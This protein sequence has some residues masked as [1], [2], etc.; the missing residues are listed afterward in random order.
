M[1]AKK[2]WTTSTTTSSCA[3]IG[4]AHINRKGEV[5]DFRPTTERPTQVW[6]GEKKISL[7]P[8]KGQEGLI[9][10]LILPIE[11]WEEVRE[12][13]PTQSGRVYVTSIPSSSFEGVRVALSQWESAQAGNRR[14]EWASPEAEAAAKVASEA[15]AAAKVAREVR[16]AE[17]RTELFAVSVEEIAKEATPA[18]AGKLRARGLDRSVL[19]PIL[20]R[21]FEAIVGE[22]SG[23]YH[24]Q[25]MTSK[26]VAGRLTAD[27]QLLVEEIVR[28]DDERRA[29]KKAAWTSSTSS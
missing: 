4:T 24:V 3:V 23:E 16:C 13:P 12:A 2:F 18:E 11:E 21:T 26:V 28:V 22:D 5:V 25:L 7:P 27:G 10:P 17:L 9:K 14:W 20:E 1:S 8:P 6:E 15:E 29:A 19:W